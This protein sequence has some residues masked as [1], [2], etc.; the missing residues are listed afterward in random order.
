MRR[1]QPH[2]A[3]PPAPPSPRRG[4]PSHQP[5]AHSRLAALLALLLLALLIRLLVRLLV[6]IAVPA[7]L[8]RVLRAAGRAG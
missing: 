2:A 1:P 8:P 4:R 6:M 7:L 3:R 5:P